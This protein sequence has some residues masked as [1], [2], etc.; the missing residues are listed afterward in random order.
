[1]YPTYVTTED[2]VYADNLDLRWP[3]FLLLFRNVGGDYNLPFSVISALMSGFPS[4]GVE[5]WTKNVSLFH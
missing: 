2:Q 5:E 1:M 4:D 3:A